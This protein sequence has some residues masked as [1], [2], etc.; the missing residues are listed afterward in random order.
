M[1]VTPYR[2]GRP[3]PNEEMEARVNT[4]LAE[5]DSLLFLKWFP[6]AWFDER[7]GEW[8][9]RYGLCARW[10][11]HDMRWETLVR[12]GH[13]R[14]DAAF[15]KL[16]WFCTDLRD[17]ASTPV[18]PEQVLDR[19]RALLARCDTSRHPWKARMREVVEHN[20]RVEEERKRR[21]ADLAAQALAEVVG[22]KSTP[23]GKRTNDPSRLDFRGL[24]DEVAQEITYQEADHAKSNQD[25]FRFDAP[26]TL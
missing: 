23:Y 20:A 19:V 10:P 22:I 21:A 2:V 6:T 26:D 24:E 25:P 17:P 1:L 13:M 18:E 5:I 14:R 7:T 8:E 16:G 9:G 11:E 15:D 12:A 4:H 3:T